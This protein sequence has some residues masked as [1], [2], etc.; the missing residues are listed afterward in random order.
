MQDTANSV[1]AVTRNVFSFMAY[2]TTLHY[3]RRD[4]ALVILLQ[5]TLFG[6]VEA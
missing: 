4:T 5:S 1:A 6:G 3:I 2:F